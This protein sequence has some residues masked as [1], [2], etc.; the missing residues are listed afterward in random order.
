MYLMRREREVLGGK[1]PIARSVWASRTL[2]NRLGGGSVMKPKRGT[3][4]DKEKKLEEK[5]SGFDEG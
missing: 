4:V 3:I 5:K 1:P 2:D